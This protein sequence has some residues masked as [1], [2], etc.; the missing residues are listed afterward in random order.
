MRS[1]LIR[2]AI[3][4]RRRALTADLGQWHRRIK[5]HTPDLR[6]DAYWEGDTLCF[7]AAAVRDHFR[8]AVLA[9]SFLRNL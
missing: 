8:T 5:R 4:S 7:G 2:H 9:G 1:K 3:A 6:T